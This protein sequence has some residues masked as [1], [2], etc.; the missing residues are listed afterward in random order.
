[1][2][3]GET[4]ARVEPLPPE[5]AEVAREAIGMDVEVGYAYSYAGA[6]WLD[7]WTWDGEH[8]LYNGDNYWPLD[9]ETSQALLGK[10]L[11]ELDVPLTY[12]F[13][14]LLVILVV[15]GIGYGV[16]RS[17]E[18]RRHTEVLAGSDLE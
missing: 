14:P 10:S 7:I 11:S 16:W 17:F 8:C 15:G 5:A 3:S 12:R 18:G 2:T 9:E 13:P 6:F 1:M 4:I